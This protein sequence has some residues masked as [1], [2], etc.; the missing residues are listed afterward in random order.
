MQLGRLW[1]GEDDTLCTSV[2]LAWR[3]TSTM[4]KR[5]AM[6]LQLLSNEELSEFSGM[7]N[8]CLFFIQSC[9]PRVPWL[10]RDVL[11]NTDSG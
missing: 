3:D 8:D 11:E 6:Y 1:I 9:L 10:S 2:V 7:N 5:P 4:T